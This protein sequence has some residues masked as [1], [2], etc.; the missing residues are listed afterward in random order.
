MK[1]MERFINFSD[2]VMA[3]AVTLLIL[4]LTERALNSH[5]TSLHGF[6]QAYGHLLLVF[7]LSFVVICR[8]WEVHHNLLNSLKTFNVGLFWLNAMW[9]LSIVVIPFT[10]ELIGSN[11]SNSVFINAV[12]IFSLMITA[13]IGYAIQLLA[14]HSPALRKPSAAGSLSNSY[15]LV[16]ALAMTAALLIAILIPAVGVWSLLILVF[17]AYVS[18]YLRR[19]FASPQQP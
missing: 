19:N 12:Y 5:I 1:D 11:D 6:E 17:A 14:M 4:P 8:Y 7:I 18:R 10:S 13:Y 15:G 16:S 9:L 2:A 3:I